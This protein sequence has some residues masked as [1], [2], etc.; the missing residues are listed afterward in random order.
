MATLAQAISRRRPTV[1][2]S[3]SNG[4]RTSPTRRSFREVDVQHHFRIRGRVGARQ[5][6]ADGRELI[7]RLLLA[8]AGPQSANSR[9]DA[10]RPVGGLRRRVGL[11]QPHRRPQLELAGRKGEPL[12]SDADHRVRRAAERQRS[13]DGAAI[14]AE[15]GLPEPVAEDHGLL[16]VLVGAEVMADGGSDAE[17]RQHVAGDH[18]AEHLPGL[19]PVLEVVEVRRPR[20]RLV[21]RPAGAAHVEIVGIRQARDDEAVGIAIGQRLQQHGVDHAEDGGGGADAECERQGRRQREGAVAQQGPERVSKVVHG[22]SSGRSESRIERVHTAKPLPGAGAANVQAFLP[23]LRP[24]RRGGCPGTGSRVRQWDR[25][26][27]QTR[28]RPGSDPGLTPSAG[29][30]AAINRCANS[31]PRP[32]SSCLK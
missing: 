21:K 28:V 17:E 11:E 18:A 27:G 14:A 22:W 8:D 4:R 25:Y 1:P 5:V 2:S 10:Q 31:G 16:T 23:V 15:D 24:R 12:R 32:C 3:T 20:G 9:E 29:G 7:A 19:V 6:A 13:S 30:S 26:W